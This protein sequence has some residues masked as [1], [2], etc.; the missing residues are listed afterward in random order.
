MSTTDGRVRDALMAHRYRFLWAVQKLVPGVLADLERDVLPPFR[1]LF[2]DEPGMEFGETGHAVWSPSGT[3]TSILRIT[4]PS[5]K[6]AR[7]KGEIWF[8][9]SW[10]AD[11]RGVPLDSGRLKFRD[12]VGNA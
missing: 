7:E 4:W 5:S 10:V 1:A 3:S 2:R 9:P 8:G 6:E 12:D 11:I